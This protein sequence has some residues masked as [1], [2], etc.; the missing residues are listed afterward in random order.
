MM[1]LMLVTAGLALI[2]VAPTA[3]Q[4]GLSRDT[5]ALRREITQRVGPGVTDDDIL[6]RIQ[7]S[8][9]TTEQIRAQLRQM[10]YDPGLLDD[11]LAGGALGTAGGPPSAELE[12]ALRDL[13]LTGAPP[14]P[15]SLYGDSIL[16]EA[17]SS[18]IFGKTLFARA[19]RQFEPALAGPVPSD[20]RLG[21]GDELWLILTGDVQATY[22]VP[23][24]PDGF[25]IIPEVG[26]VPA[27][28]LTVEQLE[29]RLYTHLGRVYSGVRRG[30][31][32]ST[33]FQVSMGRLRTNHVF[34]VGEVERPSGYQV[35]PLARTFNAL[36]RAGGPNEVG[37]FREV[38][39][40]RDGRLVAVV[41]LYPYLL[42]GEVTEDVRLEQGDMIFV[43]LA[44]PRVRMEG[45]VRRSGIFELKPGEG[46]RDALAFAGGLK[47][48][49]V[50]QRV[51]VDRILPA[52]EREPGKERVLVDVDVQRLLTR[53]GAPIDLK[54]GD[55]VR[56][57]EVGM[58]RR[59]RVT[60]TGAVRHP[61]QYQWTPEMTLASLVGEAQGLEEGAYTSRAH[62]YRLQEDNTRRLVPASL[63]GGAEPVPLADRDSVVVLRED[64][65]RLA[66]RVR[67]TGMVKNPGTYALASDMSVRDLVLMAGGFREGANTRAAEVARSVDPD[68]R[69]PETA[70][71]LAV[72][73][74]SEAGA[75]DG[76]PRWLPEADEFRLQRGDRIYVRRAPGYEAVRAV[77]LTGE[78]MMPGAYELD[79]R[80]TRISDVIRRAGGLTPEAYPPGF[81]IIREG[82]PIAG[83]L[84][85]AL[86]LPGAPGDILLE[87][88]DS[89]HIP[90]YD[91]TVEISGAVLFEAKVLYYEGRSLA[92]YID[93]AGGFAEGADT[94]R[95]VV[96][97]PN[98][99]RKVVETLLLF[100][101][102]PVVEPG[103]SIFVPTLPPSE[104]T[105]VNWDQVIGRTS[106]V[107]GTLA[108]LLVLINQTN[109]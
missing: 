67:I 17:A 3:G 21:P 46:L 60:I 6:R 94:D 91:G 40:R 89:L 9:M 69:T 100:R 99:E 16:A 80:Q 85:R 74:L 18:R 107:I 41:D 1:R 65:L 97:Y 2:V 8:G 96:T 14:P 95:V 106:A 68:A 70:E 66:Q 105:G 82:R 44:G 23:V 78:V 31:E 109:P 28:G 7:Q 50:L 15:D 42:S 73:L 53:E 36:Y 30:P 35:S 101:R 63:V 56:F 45:A 71:V 27:A 57:F 75:L 62:I 13:E 22:Q 102:S 32:A 5:A 4:G 58:E 38:L 54:D 76:V 104:R 77:R 34:V 29:D 98:G 33:H 64:R 84:T 90:V 26:R 48:N 87:G 61:G 12:A 37:S 72:P 86:R 47:A 51:Q 79:S 19:S 93:R 39:V 24:L 11:Y 92:S 52:S 43:P 83:D 88:G 25:I 59:N 55:I 10:G 108:T 49:A 103:S 20:Y 81:A